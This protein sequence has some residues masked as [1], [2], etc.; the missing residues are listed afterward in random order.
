MLLRRGGQLPGLPLRVD[1]II[2]T[3][4]P[5]R[6]KSWRSVGVPRLLVLGRYRMGFEVCPRADE[7]DVL[8]YVEWDP[9]PGWRGALLRGAARRYAAWF[10]DSAVRGAQGAFTLPA[11][12]SSHSSNA[13]Q[14]A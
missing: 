11:V 14:P 9:L 4:E 10:V 1:E 8:V 12:H 7:T 5:G 13:N 3:Y 2:D 6:K